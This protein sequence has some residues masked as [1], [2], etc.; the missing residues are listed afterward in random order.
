[1]LNGAGDVSP[2]DFQ[3]PDGGNAF[4]NELIDVDTPILN[5]EQVAALLGCSAETVEDH[6]RSGRLPGYKFGAGWIFSAELLV[7]AVKK[8]SLLNAK[9]RQEPGKPAG[10]AH[11]KGQRKVPVGMSLMTPEILALLAPH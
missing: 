4:D 7:E 9:E 3:A 2:G 11:P 8:M 10:Y 5:A 1:M 6:A